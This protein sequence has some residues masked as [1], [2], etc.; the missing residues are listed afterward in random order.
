[1]TDKTAVC[2]FPWELQILQLVHA[3]SVEEVT[4]D[5]L[6]DV[7]QGAIKVEKIKLKHTEHP[8]PGLRE[9]YE[10]MAY[11]DPEE[12]PAKD[13]RFGVRPAREQVRH[14]QGLPDAVH[15][16]GVRALGAG[17]FKRALEEHAD[18]VAPKP[19]Y[20]KALDEGMTRSPQD[21]SVGELRRELKERGIKWS[22]REGQAELAKK[23]E[24]ALAPA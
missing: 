12:D 18:D 15:R 22:P 5:K 2:V 7:K 14:G 10:I 20:L 19:T 17:N 13:P 11:V 24:G 21:M 8:A 6:C 4:I 1:M 23:L 9:Q 3:D 16:A